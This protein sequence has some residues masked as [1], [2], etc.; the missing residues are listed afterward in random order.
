MRQPYIYM[1]QN[2]TGLCLETVWDTDWLVSGPTKVCPFIIEQSGLVPGQP[3]SKALAF[4][5]L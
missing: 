5:A 2:G 3:Q 4:T 1:V